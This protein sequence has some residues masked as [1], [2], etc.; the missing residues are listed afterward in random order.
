MSDKGDIPGDLPGPKA[1]ESEEE[2][3]R[4]ARR[5]RGLANLR[6][7][8]GPNNPP[9]RSPGRP[10]GVIRRIDALT[11]DGDDI[12]EFFVSVMLKG[13]TLDGRKVRARDSIEAAKELMIRKF[14]KPV[15]TS[16]IIDAT[17]AASEGLSLES[18]ALAALAQALLPKARTI[19]LEPVNGADVV[20]AEFSTS[21]E[22]QIPEPGQP[23]AQ[24][25]DTTEGQTD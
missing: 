8:W 16:V 25:L 15:D 19:S 21:P 24:T 13:E 6:P 22:P 11:R 10:A 7:P 5:K 1:D 2:A 9:P 4:E 12:I 3:Q 23:S 17:Q 14:G 20:D 18:G